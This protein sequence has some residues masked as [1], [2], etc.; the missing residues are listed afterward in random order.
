MG[1][2][3]GPDGG[4]SA[5]FSPA[6]GWPAWN[7]TAVLGAPVAP[8]DVGRFV[9]DVTA[10]DTPGEVI[11]ETF[12]LQTPD[13]ELISCPNGEVE[14]SI[15]VLPG[16]PGAGGAG[17]AGGSRNADGGAPSAASTGSSSGCSYAPTDGTW[18]WSAEMTFAFLGLARARRRRARR[19]QRR[20][21]LRQRGE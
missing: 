1:A 20:S 14:P 13:G 17:G 9:F 16:E 11:A 12:Q 7:V 2:R 15:F 5:F 19:A 21:P 8:G 3:G 6:N 4:V 10:P 18:G